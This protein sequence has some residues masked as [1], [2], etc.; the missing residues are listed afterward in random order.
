MQ[1][2]ICSFDSRAE[3]ERAAGLL[4][5]R[6]MRR[7]FLYTK[8]GAS[9]STDGPP[10]SGVGDPRSPGFFHR[11]FSE[12]FGDDDASTKASHYEDAVARGETV[13]IVDVADDR[14][15]E[16]VRSVM[17]T[18]G[19][20]IDVEGSRPPAAPD[21][22][23]GDAVRPIAGPRETAS[24]SERSGVVP[25]V[26]EQ[27]QVGKRTVARGGIRVVKR[28][29]ETPVSEAIRLFEER[30]VI[31]RRPVDRAVTEADFAAFGAGTLEVRE[32]TEEPVVAKAARVVE[33]VVVVKE[34]REREETISD[35]VRRTDVDVEPIGS[36]GTTSS[37]E[38]GA[39]PVRERSTAPQRP[40]DPR[41]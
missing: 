34:V 1:T 7:D 3:A 8:A 12:L 6:G 24:T 17:S 38:A 35:S 30:A 20:S 41:P 9:G 25:V 10:A 39:S 16:I 23:G 36:R 21:S 18:L 33:E 4:I 26:E 40:T 29:V 37:R 11:L 5:E 19:G 31:E 32:R 15:L 13:L 22:T 27:L 2:V 28:I 14:E